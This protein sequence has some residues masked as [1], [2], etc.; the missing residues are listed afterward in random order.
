MIFSISIR[1]GFS[2]FISAVAC[3]VSAANLPVDDP[4]RLDPRIKPI[5]QSLDL[6]LDPEAN[7]YTGTTRIELQFNTATNRFRFHAQGIQLGNATLDGQTLALT[8][9]K[10]G[11]VSAAAAQVIGPGY[12]LLEIAFTNDFSRDGTGL[13]KVETE[14]KAYLFTQMEPTDARTAFPCWDEPGFKIPWRLT[15]TVPKNLEAVA[16]IPV[17]GTFFL[18]EHKRLEYGRTPP[19]PS[20]LVAMAVGPFEAIPIPGQAVPGRI[21]TVAGKTALG[22]MAAQEAPAL[23][24]ALERYFG[25]P[26]PFPKLDHIAVPEFNFGAMENVGL[27]TYKDGLLLL[28]SGDTSLSSRQGLITVLTHEMAHMWFGNL[29]TMQW[30]DDLWLNEAF[31]SWMAAKIAGQ[32]HPE[33]RFELQSYYT[34]RGARGND[35][36][37]SV[38]PVRRPFK[39]GDNLQEAFDTLS[40]GKGQAIL[41]M[42]EGW[43]GATNFQAG[44]KRYFVQNSWGNARA[45]DLWAVFAEAGDEAL[46]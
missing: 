43:I 19:M 6:Q 5:T 3:G 26:H 2:T 13:Y 33:L 20:Y 35:V 32:V 25:L 28:D 39:G 41:G 4:L 21:L 18:G 16:N 15:L 45:S 37:P 23:L 30:W 14:G 40:Y 34:V 9:Q 42:I 29:V 10:A 8:A 17:A 12:H 27:I 46:P 1:V 22:K 31:A 24:A 36:Q 38:K 7:T 44:L 11:L